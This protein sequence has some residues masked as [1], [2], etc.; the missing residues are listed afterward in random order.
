MEQ[1]CE[2]IFNWHIWKRAG[3]LR[4]GLESRTLNLSLKNQLHIKILR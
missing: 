4:T 2:Q 1:T 3:H